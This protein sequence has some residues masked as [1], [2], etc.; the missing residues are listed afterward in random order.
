MGIAMIVISFA[1]EIVTAAAQALLPN[2]VAALRN[3]QTD[4]ENIFN[5]LN[6]MDTLRSNQANCGACWDALPASPTTAQITTCAADFA[7]QTTAYNQMVRDIG[8]A[9]EDAQ[10]V[11]GAKP[12]GYFSRA[13]TSCIRWASRPNW[14]ARAT[15]CP[16]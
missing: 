12:G 13:F 3:F 5:W 2:T 8:Q 7:N 6:T 1:P 10:T 11:C 15:V 9:K 4:C 16:Y 14:T